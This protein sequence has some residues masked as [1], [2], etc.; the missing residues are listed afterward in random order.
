MSGKCDSQNRLGTFHDNMT[1]T[2]RKLIEK[3]LHANCEMHKREKLVDWVFFNP[4]CINDYH[5]A[6]VATKRLLLRNRRSL[7][8]I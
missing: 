6:I 7:K 8:G 2:N 5:G 3:N 1:T 4:E